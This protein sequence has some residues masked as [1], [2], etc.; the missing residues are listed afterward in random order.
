[1][2]SDELRR[3][4]R[5]AGLAASVPVDAVLVTRLV[6]VRYLT[7]FSGSSA[8][9]LLLVGGDAPA[10]VL[11]TDGRYRDQAA[12]QCGDVE[13]IVSRT[14]PEDLLAH[15]STVGAGVVGFEPSAVSVADF[16]R[17]SGGF[18][19]A[20]VE[21]DSLVEQLRAVK[22]PSEIE[23]LRRACQ[24]SDAAL[25]EVLPC[26]RTGWTERRIAAD[27]EAAMRRLGADGAAFESIVAG[28]PHSAI[29]HHEPTDRPLAKG[30]LLKIDFGARVEGYHADQTRT[31]VVGAAAQGWQSDLHA[32][33]LAAQ[34]A[35][36]AALAPGAS[37]RTVDQ[38]ARSVVAAAGWG[39]QFTHGLGHGV[40]LEI[41]E[42]PFLGATS[43]DRLAVAVP[44][45]V[46]PGV[47]LPGRGGVRIE[48]T[49]VVGTDT[50]ESLTTT[51]R[52]LLVLDQ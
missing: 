40:G 9:L 28:G 24:V 25:A 8:A 39:D 5:L 36:V 6:N 21:L 1:M 47:Y 50:A 11:A 10:A 30:D 43:P 4:S 49:L 2:P 46:E 15:A 17:L 22:D 45:T 41:H 16:R 34:E 44:V 33:V 18:G 3:R 27:L 35:G 48:D 23:R 12:Q 51:S 19:G 52:D 31:F 29:P 20:M 37:A 42:A 7:G 26:I 32:A 14:G 13:L 38:A